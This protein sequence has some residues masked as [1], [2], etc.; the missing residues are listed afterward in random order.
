[1]RNPS[2]GATVA[3]GLLLLCLLLGSGLNVAERGLG[4]L[5]GAQ[6]A[7]SIVYFSRST[8]GVYDIAFLGARRQL[9]WV[10]P[11]AWIDASDR[12][13]SLWTLDGQQQLQLNLAPTILVPGQLDGALQEVRSAALR[14]FG[15]VSDAVR[16]L[17]GG[18]GQ[19]S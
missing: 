11:L 2:A 8:G 16:Q 7:P 14:L 13:L 5:F 19:G 3:I 4:T 6:P 15:G 10:L 9:S 18:Q 1:M 17:L 12:R